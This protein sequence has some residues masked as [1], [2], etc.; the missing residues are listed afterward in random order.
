[1]PLP[2]PLLLMGVSMTMTPLLLPLPL[3]LHAWLLTIIAPLEVMGSFQEDEVLVSAPPSCV[4]FLSSIRLL[5]MLPPPVL[6][7][8][9]PFAAVGAAASPAGRSGPGGGG[10]EGARVPAPARSISPERRGR[11]SRSAQSNNVAAASQLLFRY[12]NNLPSQSSNI[13]RNVGLSVR[14]TVQ[15]RKETGAVDLKTGDTQGVSRAELGGK[16]T[17]GGCPGVRAWRMVIARH[18]R[19]AR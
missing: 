9:L 5:L 1:M 16:G 6:V 4:M 7:A 13:S 19:R 12:C 17:Q 14:P 10:S 2:L 8:P 3:L 18:V 11:R 15:M